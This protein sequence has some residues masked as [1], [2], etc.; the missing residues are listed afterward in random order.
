M[1]CS[2]LILYKSLGISEKIM[3]YRGKVTAANYREIL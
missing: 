1:D 3:N 2:N